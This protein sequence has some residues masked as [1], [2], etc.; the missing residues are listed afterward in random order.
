MLVY[1]GVYETYQRELKKEVKYS[2]KLTF[3]KKPIST[4]SSKDF[5]LYFQKK[6]EEVYEVPYEVI[7]MIAACTVMK[8]MTTSF[9]KA[10]YSNEIVLNFISHE[11]LKGK[12]NGKL[13][14]LRTLQY[15]VTDFLYKLK[16]TEKKSFEES[17]EV[18]EELAKIEEDTWSILKNHWKT[19]K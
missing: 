1:D 5:V 7:N 16:S 2:T 11:L 17:K 12:A 8:N 13:V 6:F 18:F 19:K 9:Y 10:G 4:Y 3:V 15:G 14:K